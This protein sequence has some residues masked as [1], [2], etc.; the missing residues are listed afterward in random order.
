MLEVSLPARSGCVPS[1][2]EYISASKSVVD[3]YFQTVVVSRH[4]CDVVPERTDSPLRV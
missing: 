1:D 3:I 2:L 4:L